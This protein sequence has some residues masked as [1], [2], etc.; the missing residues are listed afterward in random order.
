MTSVENAAST[1]RKIL[2][3]LFSKFLHWYHENRQATHDL[4]GLFALSILTY[5]FIVKNGLVD[6]F[7]AF[8]RQ[9]EELQLDELVLSLGVISSLYVSIF[10][11]RRWREATRRLEQANTDHLTRLYNRYKGWEVLEYELARARRYQRPLSIIIMD[12]DSF[13]NIND[14]YGHLAGDHILKAVARIAR[15]TVRSVDN[16]IRWGG[17]EFVVM[18]PDTEL[19]EALH[20]A[21][22]LREAIAETSIEILNAALNITVSLGVAQRDENTPDLE[23]LLARADQAMYIA[24]YLGRNRVARSK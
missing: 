6:R 7:Y 17:E 13:K 19:R 22:R 8:T 16:L 4:I 23:T 24:K 15:E 1:A 20:V 21:E 18:L 14:T 9:H 12:I 2:K 5:V 3:S 11:I 10:A